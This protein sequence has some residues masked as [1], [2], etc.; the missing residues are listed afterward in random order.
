ME[1]PVY[2]VGHL[3]PDTDSICSA[4]AYA[5]LKNALGEVKVHP[6]RAGALNAESS[7]VLKEFD[8]PSPRLL[9][10]AT[11]LTLILVDHS[12]AAQALPNIEHA[13][14]IEIVEHHRFGDLRP[15]EPIVIHCEPVGATAT[16][17]AEFYFLHELSPTPAMAGLL[18]AAI[19]SDTVG[20]RSPTTTDKDHLL[21]KRLQTLAGVDADALNRRLSEARTNAAM[22]Q[23]AE[24]IVGSDFKQFR[25]GT[26]SVG[27]GQVEI[28][29]A[30]ALDDRRPDVFAAMRQL[31]TQRKLDQ[32]IMMVTDTSAGA[33]DLWVVGDRID[34]IEQVFGPV[35]DQSVHIPGC[36]SRKKQIVP[37]LEEA[38]G[39]LP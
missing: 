12:E 34:V 26:V 1:T 39:N 28:P 30:G 18:L 5:R 20:F 32:L 10:D 14:I 27:I 17:I 33:S 21:A 24:E 38:F 19:L 15:A 35:R 8:V 3:N 31:C 2:V 37:R 9:S 7:M 25:F 4:I 23:S 11:G 6:A 36:M 13:R 22:S 16:L 29:V